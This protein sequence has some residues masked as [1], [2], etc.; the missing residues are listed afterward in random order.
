MDEATKE[1]KFLGEIP[2][3][4]NA[5]IQH[6]NELISNNNDEISYLQSEFDEFE[7]QAKK[8][9]DKSVRNQ[10]KEISELPYRKEKEISSTLSRTQTT[11]IRKGM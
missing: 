6:L 10:E 11:F 5:E 2:N 4:L 3:K 7:S 1:K 9:L 8:E